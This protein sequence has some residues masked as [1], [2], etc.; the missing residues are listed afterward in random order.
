MLAGGDRAVGVREGGPEMGE[1]VRRRPLRG[2]I[3]WQLGRRAQPG[4]G[5][6]DFA[7]AVV[8]ALPEALP[9]PVA[10]MAVGGAAGSN[11]AAGD[12]ALEEAPQRAG[13]QAEAADF[14][15]EPDGERPPAA[16]ACIAVAA[17]DAAG[18]DRLALG[19]GVIAVQKAMANQGTGHLAVRT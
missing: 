2:R 4:Q 17:K 18:A 9:G 16:A 1:D 11:D 6:A 19:I 10:E 3:G 13:G 15:G 14:V 5:G 7:L 12:G 8:E